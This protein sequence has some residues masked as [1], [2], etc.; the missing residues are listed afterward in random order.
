MRWNI[1]KDEGVPDKAGLGMGLLDPAVKGNGDKGSK[2]RVILLVLLQLR[3]PLLL[4]IPIRIQLR[5]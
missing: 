2:V 5:S 3:V 4:E 1:E